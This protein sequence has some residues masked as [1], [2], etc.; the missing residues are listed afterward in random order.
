MSSF[1]RGVVVVLIGSAA[2]AA[3]N[4]GPALDWQQQ[5]SGVTVRLRGVSAVS[6]GVAWA[7]GAEGTVLRTT[8][9]GETWQRRP[10]PGAE[11]SDF[12]DVD[13]FSDRVAYV[14]SIGPG[15]ASRIYKTT[16]GGERWDLQFKNPDPK[17]FL[18]AMTFRDETHGLAFGDSVDGALVIL[19]TANGGRSWERVA[20]DHLPAALPGEGAFAASGDER[21]DRR[22]QRLDRHECGTRAAF[23]RLRCHLDGRDHAPR[24]GRLG[25]HLFGRVPRHPPR[26][27]GRR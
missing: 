9:G 10:V 16:D 22:A 17:G 2:G 6:A 21:G 3:V 19:T 18:D 20:R 26:G 15:E 5:A 4:P 1:L 12:R 8:D 23:C 25:G 27:C 7:S 11:G 13:A 24:L 14:L